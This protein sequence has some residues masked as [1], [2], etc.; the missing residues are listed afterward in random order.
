MTHDFDDVEWLAHEDL[1]AIQPVTLKSTERDRTWAIPPAVP[2]VR[3]L[4]VLDISSMQTQSSGRGGL[5]SGRLR[6]LTDGIV[7]VTL[8]SIV[9]SKSDTKPN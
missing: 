1:H 9:K 3:S 4:T 5:G 8:P 2:A 7:A 6:K